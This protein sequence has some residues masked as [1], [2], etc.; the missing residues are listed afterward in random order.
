MHILGVPG[1]V[2][3]LGTVCALAFDR[4]GLW[5]GTKAFGAQ[6]LGGVYQINRQ[7]QRIPG[8]RP[9]RCA[10][11]LAPLAWL[12]MQNPDQNKGTAL[13]FCVRPCQPT[14]HPHDH[15]GVAAKPASNPPSMFNSVPVIYVVSSDASITTIA[16]TSWGVP[17]RLSSVCATSA[18]VVAARSGLL[19]SNGCH[20]GVRMAAAQER[21]VAIDAV[22]GAPVGQ[23]GMCGIM[24]GQAL[25]KA[26]DPGIVDH[27]VCHRDSVGQPQPIRL[28]ANIELFKAAADFGSGAHPRKFID[29]GYDDDGAF[30]MKARGRYRARRW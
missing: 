3:D 28:T 29:I 15:P 19:A 30:L 5:L 1:T 9:G 10:G 22:D 2:E 21:A 4:Q 14:S 13:D 18:A 17:N 25:F 8:S 24:G 26:G 23:T 27:D 12:S 20:I 6:V 11:K 16:A 7:G